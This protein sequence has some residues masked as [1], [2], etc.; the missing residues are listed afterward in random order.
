MQFV[1]VERTLLF[2]TIRFFK[3]SAVFNLL[4]TA[5]FVSVEFKFLDCSFQF[6]LYSKF[7]DEI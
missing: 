1:S 4:N 6:L 7:E 5:V 2:V 3:V